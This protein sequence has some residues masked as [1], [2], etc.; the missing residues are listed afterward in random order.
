[1][2]VEQFKTNLASVRK[3]IFQA[4]ERSGR[5]PN[6]VRLVGVTK[7]VDAY[8]TAQLVEA[9]CLELGENRPQSL[10]E[11]A[12]AI[13]DPRIIWHLIGH[14][15]R[16]KIKRTI[17]LAALIH[18][19]DSDRLLTAIN[20]LAIESGRIVNVLLEVNVSGDAAKHGYSPDQ[21]GAALDRVAGC[22]NIRVQGL[23]C[24]AGLDSN[25]EEARL[26]F[27]RLREIRDSLIPNLPSNAN[28]SD[29]SMGMSGDFEIA[30]EEGSTIVRVGSLLFEKG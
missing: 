23:M 24:M 14:L 10:W 21:M 5:E 26:E 19:V 7:Y 22:E 6:S 12:A 9:G 17:E 25:P 16:N 11:K 18:S 27:R 8:V 20:E 28:L 2:L 4:T 30:I 15:Q 1:M 29:L 3:R 13:S